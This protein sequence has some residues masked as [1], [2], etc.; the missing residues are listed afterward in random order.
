MAGVAIPA[1]AA[2]WRDGAGVTRI[3]TGQPACRESARA[4]IVPAP[5]A[6]AAASTVHRPSPIVVRGLVAM[7]LAAGCSGC[8]LVRGR[9]Q[10][11]PELAAT[12]RLCNEGLSAVDQRD[13][14]RAEGLFE[15]AVRNCPVDVDA[16]RHYADVLW[17]RGE[18]MEAV[19]QVAQ[20]LQLSPEDVGLAIAGGRMYLE[21]GLFD[22]AE[23]LSGTAVRLAPRSADAWHLRGQLALARGQAEAALAD[24]HKAL[25]IE[26]G[27]RDVLLDTAEAYR[28]LG[29]PQ[30]ALATLAILGE[31]YGPNQVPGRV[32]LL[33]GMAQESLGREADA[34][35]SYR[36]AIARG[37][38]PAEAGARL[39]ALEGR[40]LGAQ[41]AEAPDATPRR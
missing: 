39:A 21:L 17:K 12:R 40:K 29:R 38:A 37:D 24:L 10:A 3:C 36:R 34:V 6:P 8:R 27:D 1:R 20:A 25:A 7:L 18:R 33:E 2:D 35:E 22:D 32:L 23:R 5:F 28:R 11:P 26:P 30:R 19:A 16:R 9:G 15:Q 4:A 13:L 41:V 31:S 14:V